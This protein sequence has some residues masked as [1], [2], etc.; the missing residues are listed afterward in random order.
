MEKPNILYEDNQ[1]LVAWK[2]AGVA[3]QS[4]GIGQPDMESRIKTWLSGKT[5]ERVPYLGI[6]HRLDQPVEGL[7]VF[8]RTRE[9]AAGLSRQLTEQRMKKWYLAVVEKELK[10][11][12][13]YMLEDY[14][15]KERQQAVVCCESD[16]KAKKALLICRVIAAAEGKSLL[17]IELLTG[18]FHQIRC[19]LSHRGMP[20][21]GDVRYGGSKAIQQKNIAL[22]A[23]HLVFEHPRS[24]KPLCFTH[25]PSG[26][27]FGCFE[28]EIA[29][30]REMD[31][32]AAKPAEGV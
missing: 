4:S 18:R 32:T 16:P 10:P 13:E 19:Q 26:E 30:L 15:K 9:A 12:E 25:C 20:I 3:V 22:C 2:E 29:G 5:R 21:A 6:V 31:F 28:K 1:L 27:A 7:V 17:L 23:G 11:G 8:G 24:G 14:L